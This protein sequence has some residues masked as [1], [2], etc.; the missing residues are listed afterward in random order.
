MAP[1]KLRQISIGDYLVDEGGRPCYRADTYQEALEFFGDYGYDEAYLDQAMRAVGAY[2]VIAYA[3]DVE[4]GD[5][6]EDVEAGETY[7]TFTR[8]HPDGT[9]GRNCVRFWELSW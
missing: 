4:N 7:Y 6:P 5:V 9:P 8:L 2:P 3:A 1:Y